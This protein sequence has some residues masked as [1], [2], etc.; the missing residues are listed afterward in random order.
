M[1][2]KKNL[3]IKI[4]ILFIFLFIIY[5]FLLKDR[6]ITV[7]ETEI[8]YFGETY[9]VV[10]IG[11]LCWMAE[12]LKTTMY[13]DG[14]EIQRI[15]EQKKW[16]ETR[17]GAYS[18]P[19]ITEEMV[20]DSS[21]L[22]SDNGS[23]ECIEELKDPEEVSE[24][25]NENEII[26]NFGYLYNFYAIN[27]SASIC[28]EG[29]YLPTHADWIDLERSVCTSPSCDDD[30][31]YDMETE[32]I[33][34]TNEGSK[35]AGN[36][37]YWNRGNLVESSVFGF[38]GFNAIPAGYRDTLGIFSGQGNSA[39]FW[40]L[41]DNQGG[42]W[43]REI[44]S[45]YRGITR[46]YIQ[47]FYGGLSAR[48][49]K[50][51][52]ISFK[53]RPVL[54]V[55]EQISNLFGSRK[56]HSNG[57]K[58]DEDDNNDKGD[59]DFILSFVLEEKIEESKIDIECPEYFI[60]NRDGQR[61]GVIQIGNQCWMAENL[62]YRTDGSFCSDK[63]NIYGCHYTW[64]SALNSCPKGWKLPTDNEWK[65][66][67]IQLGME[68]EDANNE[69]WRSSGEVGG[70]LKSKDYWKNPN[71]CYEICDSSGFSALPAGMGWLTFIDGSEKINLH[72]AGENAYFWTSSED[73]KDFDDSSF[74]RRLDYNDFGISR[75]LLSCG[76]YYSVRCIKE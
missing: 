16:E 56:H 13:K 68:I 42:I 45:S 63:N 22:E 47:P 10:Q 31:P 70:K 41:P 44:H 21:C 15:N 59:E 55:K 27:N 26:E 50:K 66:L 11:N 57:D 73:Y 58:S 74:V 1:A 75:E 39:Y 72:N 32:G 43:K 25:I 30:F 4:A 49:V 67:E 65:I 28:P 51:N 20:L 48:C 8:E 64:E 52:T 29:W 24:L 6:T 38:S 61:Y 3:F 60:D 5:F 9:E 40:S 53:E 62:N 12:N 46:Q 23:S 54:F 17:Q 35:L 33:R 2:N 34:G 7:C 37:I 71:E 69:W 76:F 18:V 36:K 14:T 19:P